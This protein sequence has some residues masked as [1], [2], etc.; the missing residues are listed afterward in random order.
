MRGG[1]QARSRLIVMN[2][3]KTKGWGTEKK[4]NGR[5]EELT[6]VL[7]RTEVCT[8]EHTNSWDIQ[9]CQFVVA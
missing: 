4:K 9:R 3:R 1:F 7:K 5:N 2:R 6:V 8:A